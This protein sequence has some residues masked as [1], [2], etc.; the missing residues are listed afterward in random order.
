MLKAE[1]KMKEL[2]ISRISSDFGDITQRGGNKSNKNDQSNKNKKVPFSPIKEE[3][4]DN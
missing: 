1:G 3:D 4:V 2:E